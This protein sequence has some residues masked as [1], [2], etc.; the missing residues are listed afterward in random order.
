MRVHEAKI[1]VYPLKKGHMPAIQIARLHY[2]EHTDLNFEVDLQDYLANGFVCSRPSVFGMVKLIDWKGQPAWFVRMAV[3]NV[4]E[5][6]QILPFPLETIVFCRNNQKDVLRVYSL[7]RIDRMLVKM[8]EKQ[9]VSKTV[10]P[11]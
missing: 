3:G 11:S 5:L 8:M 7:S 6:R 10:Q 1:S 2:L 9:N 4:L